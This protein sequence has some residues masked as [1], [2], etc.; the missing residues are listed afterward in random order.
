MNVKHLLAETIYLIHTCPKRKDFVDN[1]LVPALK[2]QGIENG[3]IFIY[4]DTQKLGNL[5]A[6]IKAAD[7]ISGQRPDIQI[8]HLQDDIIPC[9]TFKEVIET[10]YK[11]LYDVDV[12]CGFNSQYDDIDKQFIQNASKSWFSFQCIKFSNK[13]LQDFIFWLKNEGRKQHENWWGTGK[14][15]DSFFKVYIKTLDIKVLNL[16]PT[17]VQCVDDVLGGSLINGN[18][19]FDMYS[20]SF[21]DFDTE[22]QFYEDYK[23]NITWKDKLNKNEDS[24]SYKLSNTKI[25]TYKV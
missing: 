10:N 9:S 11:E 16:C 3:R 22:K 19:D 8:V 17:V 14:Y 24:I 6:Y 25:K 21:I 2:L 12:V 7:I 15:D 18:R 1:Y 23:N 13:M 20:P 5:Q 4:N